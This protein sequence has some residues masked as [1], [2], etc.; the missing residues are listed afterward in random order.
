ME[1]HLTG[2]I[3]A[4]S[5]FLIIGLF[6]PLVIKVEYHSGTRYW[7]VFLVAG[8]ISI[9]A[10]LFVEA[11][12][13]SSLLG[14]LGASLIWSIGELFHQRIRVKKGWFPMNPKR[15]HEYED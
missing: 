1:I 8:I 12:I 5:T 14:V 7:W 2:I 9:I 6:H 15:K 3:I 11:V 4:V 13:V 10:A